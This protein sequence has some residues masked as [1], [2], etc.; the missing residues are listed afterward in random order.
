MELIR[1]R[2]TPNEAKVVV[3]EV[4][5]SFPSWLSKAGANYKFRPVIEDNSLQGTIL[6]LGELIGRDNIGFDEVMDAR[7]RAEG[8]WGHDDYKLLLRYA[9][10]NIESVVVG[11]IADQEEVNMEVSR[12]I[13]DRV[14]TGNVVPAVIATERH[15]G[16]IDRDER[17]DARDAQRCRIA[18]RHFWDQMEMV[19][20]EFTDCTGTLKGLDKDLENLVRKPD[21]FTEE[22]GEAMDNMD[23]DGYE[24]V[25]ADQCTI[26]R[27]MIYRRQTYLITKEKLDAAEE[28]RAERG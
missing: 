8:I 20:V 26:W 11:T 2:V 27:Q 10:E 13:Y 3:N 24:V 14:G 21:R 6:I 1:D 7:T 18:F 12:N 9:N 4:H 22:T 23:F 28:K 25:L 5:D 19:D 15:P 17:R 16:G